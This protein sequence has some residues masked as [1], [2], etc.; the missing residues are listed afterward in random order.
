MVLLV[1]IRIPLP[2]SVNDYHIAQ[3][4]AVAE[5]SKRNTGG[6]EGVQVIKNEPFEKEGVEGQYTYKTYNVENKVPGWARALL[7]T[8]CLLFKEHAWNSYPNCRTEYSN[9][10]LSNRFKIL[11]ESKHLP[12]NGSSENPFNLSNDQLKQRRVVELNICDASSLDPSVISE[13]WDPT[14]V[15]SEK[16]CTLPLSKDFAQVANP[17]MCCYKLYTI[18]FKIPLLGS[19]VE[20]KVLS[21]TQNFLLDFHRKLVCY[22]DQWTGMTL[23]ELREHERNTEEELKLKINE[24]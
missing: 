16:V 20:N 8:G 3:L 23:E 19:S 21:S 1:E 7:P 22:I 11:I 12:D 13:K 14:I 4:Y 2:I 10:Y 9:E 24:L 5:E 6:G 15:K 17:I 18:I